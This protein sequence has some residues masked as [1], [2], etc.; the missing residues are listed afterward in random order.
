MKQK[1]P[2]PC[3]RAPFLLCA[4]IA[5]HTHTHS[6]FSPHSDSSDLIH[7]LTARLA[8]FKA[9]LSRAASAGVAAARQTTAG[10][11]SRVG[12]AA[13][14]RRWMASDLS[15]GEFESKWTSYFDDPEL[16]A[17][18]VRRGLNDV[19][20]HDLVPSAK[21]IESALRATRR[22]NDFPTSVRIF[23]GIADKAPTPD[24][25]QQIVSELKP[26]IEELHL[27]LPDELGL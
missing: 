14:Q 25:Y 12:A 17:V 15:E 4:S 20:A 1:Y 27:S 10:Q 19:F 13:L 8:M 6:F 23:E 21:I 11:G 26:V 3:G 9:V 5:S 2:R 16:P 7:T 18:Q 24:V 22:V